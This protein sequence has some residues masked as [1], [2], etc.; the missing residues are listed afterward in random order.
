MTLLLIHTALKAEAD[1]LINHFK[2]KKVNDRP[3]QIYANEQI[4][5]IISGIGK[6][7]TACSLGFA[8]NYRSYLNIGLAGGIAEMGKGFLADKI[9]ETQQRKS[10][11]PH[12]LQLDL[13]TRG[14]MTLDSPSSNYQIEHLFDL[15]A[16]SFFESAQRFTTVECIQSFKVI[17]DCDEQPLKDFDK[18]RASALIENSLPTIDSIITK[19]CEIAT[20]LNS[21]HSLPQEF[22][23]LKSQYHLT[24]TEQLKLKA[25]LKCALT[26]NLKIPLDF[27]D[28]NALFKY[29]DDQL[30]NREISL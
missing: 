27:S 29:L 26:A 8:H 10:Y 6:T 9:C 24:Q 19:L 3:F 20:S 18:K 11:F 30:L 14:I 23:I 25:Q 12:P 16:S 13:P 17:S 22:Q 15:E 21:M 2:L 5:L 4:S 7:A 28:K 1:P